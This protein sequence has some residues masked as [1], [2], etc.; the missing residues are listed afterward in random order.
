MDIAEHRRNPPRAQQL[1]PGEVQVTTGY[2]RLREDTYVPYGGYYS[3]SKVRLLDT[4]SRYRTNVASHCVY[5]VLIAMLQIQRNIGT[6]L[7]VR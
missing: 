5:T 3:T 1:V 2:A 4:V 6:R 7:L